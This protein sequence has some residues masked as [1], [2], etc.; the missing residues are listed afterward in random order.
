MWTMCD[1]LWMVKSEGYVYEID[2]VK[3]FVRFKKG[4]RGKWIPWVAF[5][6]HFIVIGKRIELLLQVGITLTIYLPSV[7]YTPPQV[8]E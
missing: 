7:R 4:S 8:T 1:G 2:T 5:D 6:H 3:K